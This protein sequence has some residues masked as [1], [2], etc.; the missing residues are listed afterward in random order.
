MSRTLIISPIEEQKVA[1]EFILKTFEIL[2]EEL[3][4]GEKICDVYNLV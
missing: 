2:I 3:K 1:Y 4:I